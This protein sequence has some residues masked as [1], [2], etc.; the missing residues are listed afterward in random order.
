MDALA[1]RGVRVKVPRVHG[2][3]L[4]HDGLL[5]A[6]HRHA[7]LHRNRLAALHSRHRAFQDTSAQP[8][9][10]LDHLAHLG[11][12]LALHQPVLDLL[13][14]S[15]GCS[16]GGL[17]L[18]GGSLHR[19]RQRVHS[20]GRSANRSPGRHAGRSSHCGHGGHTLGRRR[21]H[22]RNRRNRRGHRH[23]RN[24]R[25]LNPPWRVI[26]GQQHV[27]HPRGRSVH[28]RPSDVQHNRAARAH[29]HRLARRDTAIGRAG[30]AYGS[31]ATIG[32]INA[33]I[34]ILSDP[35]LIFDAR[36]LAASN[37]LGALL[38]ERIAQRF[39]TRGQRLPARNLCV[40]RLGNLVAG[41]VH[42]DL[43]VN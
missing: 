30:L 22:R 39:D 19:L 38:L 37:R 29:L 14:G 31:R 16:L 26:R 28:I 24:R 27:R 10:V 5:D 34:R 33:L 13:G 20:H 42:A 35:P 15:L 36:V 21:H 12:P 8:G 6:D 7:I 32:V 1:A 9:R 43:L 11:V 40:A 18:I 23:R 25:R 17:P 41:L 2:A 4:R 3:R